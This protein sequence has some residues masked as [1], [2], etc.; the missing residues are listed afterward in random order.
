MENLY[1]EYS[2]YQKNLD[3]VPRQNVSTGCKHTSTEETESGTRVC[4]DCGCELFDLD[5]EAE[6]R[7]Y[8]SSDN[9]NT[10]D[11]SRCHGNAVAVSTK[12]SIDTVFKSSSVNITMAMR[13]KVQQ[14]YRNIVGESTI[15][16]TRRKSIVAAILFHIYREE[17][18]NRTSEEIRNMFKITKQQMSEGMSKYYSKYSDDRTKHCT[19]KDLIVR[20]MQLTGIDSSHYDRIFLLTTSLEDSDAMMKH[21]NPNSVAAAVIYLYLC[22]NPRLKKKLGMTKAK[23]S[24]LSS[25]S[26]ITIAKLVRKSA[27]ILGIEVSL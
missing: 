27:E 10:S 23:F 4:K 14:R 16:G 20:I 21:S 24:A 15:R 8:G 18:D 2:Q 7:Y 1:E 11:P 6:W 19:P 13:K 9:K 3:T 17:G 12:G 22:I 25:L 5:F 26:D